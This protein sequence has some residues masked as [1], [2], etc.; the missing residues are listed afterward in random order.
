ML[1]SR[2]DSEAFD[3]NRCRIAKDTRNQSQIFFYPTPEVQLS[4]FSR[5]TVMLENLARD[6]SHDTISFETFIET[7]FLLHTTIPI[8]C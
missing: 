1:R 7:E 8:D 3:W 4:H 2:K 6:C 5:C